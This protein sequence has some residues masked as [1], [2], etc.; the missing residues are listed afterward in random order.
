[1]TV[2]AWVIAAVLAVALLA[3]P[4][5]WAPALAE[6]N[7]TLMKLGTLAFG[8]GFTLV[9]LIQHEVVEHRGWLTT[10]EFIDGIALG[11]VT[12]GPI[13]IT[14]T[15]VGY[16]IAGLAGAVGSTVAVFLPSFLILMAALPHYDRIKRLRAVR[17]MIQGILAAFIAL[18]LSVLV[19]FGRASLVDW[20]TVGLAT[21]AALALW[22][23]IDLLLIV[24]GAAIF[25]ILVF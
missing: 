3:G 16:R 24:A 2:R 12:P 4:R 11:Q 13:V 22:W 18:L 14:A 6:L 9:P 1:M 17:W 7:L 19:E 10:R 15:F 23:K 20:K 21:A 25:S 8:G 5:V